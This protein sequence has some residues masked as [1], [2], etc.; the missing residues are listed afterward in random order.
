MIAYVGTQLTVG[1]RTGQ[2]R[3]SRISSQSA[4]LSNPSQ[5][6]FDAP[7]P[8]WSSLSHRGTTR[9][10]ANVAIRVVVQ[11][12]ADDLR[13]AATKL[14]LII[15]PGNDA[16]LTYRR[17]PRRPILRRRP[18]MC[19]YQTGT[20]H[21]TKLVLIITPVV[22]SLAPGRER[23]VMVRTPPHGNF[24]H[25]TWGFGLRIAILQCAGVRKAA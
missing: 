10:S 17:N 22:E 14:V 11:S 5:T 12:F 25:Q 18:S 2:R 20:H 8:N 3:G 16:D 23:L 4:S 7:L 15:T 13:C 6:S 9:I 1:I 24:S 21:H 19:R